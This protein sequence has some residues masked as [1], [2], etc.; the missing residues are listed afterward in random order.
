MSALTNYAENRA[1]DHLL[2]GTV[3]VSLHTGDPGE[4][5]AA[6][7]AGAAIDAAYV[8]K[9]V[10]FEPAKNGRTSNKTALSWTVDAGSPG[11]TVTHIGIWDAES[12]GNAL[13][14][15]ALLAP[16]PLA[17]GDVNNAFAAGT[18]IIDLD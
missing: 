12:G 9:A 15:G 11:Y 8:R 2:A 5:G 17:A 13:F 1:L 14:K 10:T 16:L 4:D 3:Y 18:I 7:E 6:N